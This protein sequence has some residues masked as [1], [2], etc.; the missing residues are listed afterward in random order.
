MARAIELSKQG[1]PAPNPHVGCVI[2]KD[3]AVVGEGFHHYVGGAHAE[4]EAL[5]I[6]GSAA[7]GGTAYVSQ[8]PCNHMGRTGPCSEALIEAGV[9]RVVFAVR[10]P[11][12]G[13]TGG[14]ERL[15]EAGIEVIEGVMADEAAEANKKWLHAMR[16]Q[17]PYVVGKAAISLDGRIALAN[18]E[19]KWITGDEARRQAHILR[20]ECGAV[21]VGR[22]TVELD[23]PE[24]TVRHIDVA[25]Q[26]V[27]IVIDPERRLDSGRKVFND[28]A[29]THRVVHHGLS[30]NEVAVET[31]DGEVSLESLLK[32]L[33]DK[34]ITSLLV[35]GGAVTLS[36]FLAQG[37]VDRLELFVAPKLLGNGPH[38]A[39][40]GDLQTMDEVGKWKF[41]SIRKLAPEA[42]LTATPISI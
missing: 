13:A 17:K 9:A 14:A 15:R 28:A 31:R 21:L 41:E 33:F 36:K 39:S 29:P 37:L 12:P 7:R 25:N 1:Y 27:R 3:G 20:A 22:R 35:E 5:N 4:V 23:D 6:A 32:N 26:P 38:W 2:V 42:W 24:L 11:N 10:D 16:T 18:G 40:F 19:S 30:P 8:E 34:G